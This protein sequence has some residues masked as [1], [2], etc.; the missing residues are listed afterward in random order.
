MGS[1]APGIV[2]ILSPI[3]GV[4]SDSLGIRWTTILGACIGG[5]GLLASSW[6]TT[7]VKEQLDAGF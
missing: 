2:F 4:L 6:L 1:L 5:L 7:T 3:S